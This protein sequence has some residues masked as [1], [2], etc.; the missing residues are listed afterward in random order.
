MYVYVC[1]CVY[2]CMNVLMVSLC[3]SCTSVPCLHVFEANCVRMCMN[4]CMYACMN[5]WMVLCAKVAQV[6]SVCTYLK[7]SALCMRV[8]CVCVYVV[9]VCL[10]A[11]VCVSI[12]SIHTYIHTYIHTCTCMCKYNFMHWKVRV[13]A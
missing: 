4:M 8:V 7:R 3:E 13:G 2:V 5:V 6:Y 10:H 12:L 11:L 1:V 9:W